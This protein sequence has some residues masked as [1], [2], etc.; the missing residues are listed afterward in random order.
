MAVKTN[1]GLV[2]YALAQV[3]NPYWYG[4]FGQIASAQLLSAKKKQYPKYYD[5]SKYKKIFKEQ[6]GHRVFDCI[7]LIKGYLWS[8]SPTSTP[9]YK[10][11]Q[12]VDANRALTLCTESGNIKT[13]PDV[14]G[15]CVFMKNHVGV[16]I[17]GGTVV[18]A[19]G[20][21]YGVVKTQLKSRT[22]TSWGKIPWITYPE[23]KNSQKVDTFRPFKVK[24]KGDLLYIRKG[25]STMYSRIGQY[26]RGETPTILAVNTAK[27]W[28]KTDRGWICIKPAY[29]AVIK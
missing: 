10:A 17:G 7:G 4:T 11:S 20:H 6:Y 26:R 9:K 22:W 16:Y 24:I 12:D 2:S 15:V 19:R 28:G 1:T 29:V 21:D 23:Q 27:T 14:P 18:E 3:G 5:Q 25:P 8:E 13:M